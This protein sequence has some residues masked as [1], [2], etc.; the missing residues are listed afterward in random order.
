[1]SQVDRVLDKLQT[2]PA[3][4][5]LDFPKGFRLSGYIHIL[6]GRGHIIQTLRIETENGGR[7]GRYIYQGYAEPICSDDVKAFGEAFESLARR[8]PEGTKLN[9]KNWFDKLKFWRK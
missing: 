1:M 4:D 5:F 6:R 2:Q 3:V 7:M 8:L 9:K